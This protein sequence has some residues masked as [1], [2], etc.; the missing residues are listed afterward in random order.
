MI[1]CRSVTVLF[2]FC[3]VASRLYAA[4][5]IPASA[6][7]GLDG[8]YPPWCVTYSCLEAPGGSSL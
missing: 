3:L 2:Y 8:T 1:G 6:Y 5:V 7:A 4:A